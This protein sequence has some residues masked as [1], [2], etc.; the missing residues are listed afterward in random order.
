MLSFITWTAD[1]DLFHI[2]GLTVRWY[3]LLWASAV[4]VALLV[5]QKTFK[6]EKCP[7][8][9][10]EKLFYY[11]AGGLVIGARLGHCLFYGSGDDFFY[12]Y[13]NPF[14]ILFIWEGGLAS[15]GGAIGLLT[16]M[17]LFNRNVIKKGYLWML[18]RLVLGVAIGGALIRF[19]NL[20]NHEVYG[21]QTDVPWAFRFILNIHS[22]QKGAEPFFSQPSHPTQIYEMLY[23]L[24][25]FAVIMYMYWKT[26]AAQR[27][28]LI[29]GV[30]LVGIFFTRFLLEFIKETQVSFEE[31]M[32][33]NMGQLLSIP[34]FLAGFYF[35]FRKIKKC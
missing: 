18:D 20:M 26:K 11:G 24:I 23:C 8:I 34:F 5:V 12:Y 31:G 3:G 17:Y 13:R 35:I 33:L 25:T 19:G 28:G 2:G 30:F 1:P 16:A 22:W 6:H 4:W 29:F 10:G 21:C 7:E 14:E 27:T 15:H 9:W 32:M